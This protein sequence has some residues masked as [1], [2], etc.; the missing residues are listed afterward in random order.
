MLINLNG[1]NFAQITKQH[2]SN[3]KEIV[4]MLDNLYTLFDGITEKFAS[5]YKVETIGAGKT[6][7]ALKS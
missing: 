5:I 6:F 7:Q 2:Q 3:P 4:R 1:V